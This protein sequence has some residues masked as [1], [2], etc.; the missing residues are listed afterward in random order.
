MTSL[1]RH[2][3]PTCQPRKE[4]KEDR[5]CIADRPTA[6]FPSVCGRRALYCGRL[7]RKHFVLQRVVQLQS[8]G[9]WPRPP[10]LIRARRLL[11]IRRLPPV[12]TRDRLLTRDW[13]CARGVRSFLPRVLP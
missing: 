11:Y 3:E 5:E 4:K 7:P 1:L 8:P 12:P 10:T 6:S 2:A 13:P 9:P